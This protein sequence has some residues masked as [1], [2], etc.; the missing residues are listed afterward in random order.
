M[1]DPNSPDGPKGIYVLPFARTEHISR[2]TFDLAYGSLSPFQTLDLYLPESEAP[3]GGWPLLVYVHGGAWMMCDKRDIQIKEPL[4]LLDHG[5]AVASV[6]YRLSGEAVFPA[7]IHDVKAALRYLRAHA[8][9]LGLRAGDPA[10]WGASAGAHLAMLAGTTGGLRLLEDFSLGWADQ[11]SAVCAVVSWFGPTDFLMM[12]RYF[13]ETG[14]G[15]A[16][17]SVADS[18][19]SKVLGRTITE[20]PALVRAA[21]P[22]TWLTAD[23]P[24]FLFQHAAAD[25][26]VPVQH[27]IHFARRINEVAGSGRA[28]LQIVENAGHAE[29]FDRPDIV[30]R[31]ISFLKTVL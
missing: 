17:H 8:N 15:T 14:A 25:P 29:G 12:D 6:N 18:P 10:I 2:K 3:R 11:S 1:A 5:I 26:I 31:T 4:Q 27:S 21:N 22:E 7:Q 20:V 24:K 28:E 9:S 23:C 19:E 13:G 16:D 30:A